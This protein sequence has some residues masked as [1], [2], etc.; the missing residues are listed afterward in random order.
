[1]TSSKWPKT[2][3]EFT[4]EQKRIKDDFMH[5]WLEELPKKF[6]VVEIFNQRYPS[7]MFEKDKGRKPLW[8]T[9]ELGG[10]YWSTH[11]I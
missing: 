8:N 4:D 1:M 5:K 7:R 6:G 9:L 2:I 3:P 10:G 11:S